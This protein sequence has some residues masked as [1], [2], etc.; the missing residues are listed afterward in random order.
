M[1]V[2]V[3]ELVRLTRQRLHEA[4]NS[5]IGE[6]PSGVS[7]TPTVTGENGIIE[8]LNRVTAE[9]CRTCFYY[10]ATAGGLIS[11]RTFPLSGLPTLTTPTGAKLWAA[12]YVARDAGLIPL[13]HL[14][15]GVLPIADMLSATTGAPRYWLDGGEGTIE[16]YPPPVFLLTITVRGAAL[17]PELTGG[18][19]DADFLP[20]DLLRKLLPAGAASRI[21]MTEADN[22]AIAARGPLWQAEYDLER[23][24][25]WERIPLHIRNRTFYAPPGGLG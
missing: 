7:N 15:R 3:S 13:Q 14:S 8:A 24:R 17:P 19:P 18:G 20:D 5:P 10:E 21:A 11:T 22:P 6:M 12:V 16:L 25:L 4:N 2:S 1:P 9:V 23:L